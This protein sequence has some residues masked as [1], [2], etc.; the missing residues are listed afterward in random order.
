[1]EPVES[2]EPV[3]PVEGDVAEVCASGPATVFAG[4]V[5]V[6][7]GSVAVVSCES[8]VVVAVEAVGASP[9]VDEL[10]VE[11]SPVSGSVAGADAVEVVVSAGGVSV[12]GAGSA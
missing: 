5:S 6:V 11:S 10:V 2:V 12:V 9:A 3:E 1:V 4:S 7:A 8:V